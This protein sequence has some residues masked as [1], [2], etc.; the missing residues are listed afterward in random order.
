MPKYKGK[1]LTIGETTYRLG[2]QVGSGGNSY[3]CSA[4]VAGDHTQYAIKFLTISETDDNYANKKERFFREI[5]YCEKTNSKYVIKVYGHGI[6][7]GK[8]CY[9]M[10]R[11]TKTLAKTIA[12]ENDAFALLDCCLQLCDALKYIHSQSIIHRDI[13]PEN[14]F[15]DA[16]NNLVLADFGIAHFFDSSLTSSRD[17]LGNKYYAAP[18]QLL[19]GNSDNVTVA[20]DIYALGAVIN[21]LFTKQKP[22]GTNFITIS[23]KYPYLAK[24]D[25][26]VYRCLRQ[27]PIERPS[28][29]AIFNEIQLLVE[30]LKTKIDD[31]QDFLWP[32]EIVD[33]EDTKIESITKMASF[34][35]LSANYIF[36]EK[37]ADKLELYNPNFHGNVCYN[38]DGILK[39]I[40]FQHCLL[41]KCESKFAYEA[42]VYSKGKPY[43]ALNLKKKSDFQIYTRFEKLLETFSIPNWRFDISGKILKTFSS[44]C[45]YHCKE[46]IR[47]ALFIEQK[48]KD[49]DNSPIIY[50]I[51]VL[52][53]DL[54][55][56]ISQEIALEDHLSINWN[57]I[58]IGENDEQLMIQ[59]SDDKEKSILKEFQAKWGISFGKIDANYYSVSF[60]SK[61]TYIQFKNFALAFSK[62]DYVFEG[63]VLDLLR[64]QREF[65]DIVELYPLG[66]Y[67]INYVLARLFGKIDNC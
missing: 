27:D 39:S 29:N 31:I 64:I 57:T 44:C 22:N 18:E 1:T 33:L 17:W 14:I 52:R 43:H 3:I 66:D 47:E 30:E 23:D 37:S 12:E 36:G 65:L 61:D 45:D 24:L 5:E 67:E 63:D 54:N 10:P 11:Y 38:V 15:V 8:L 59:N 46:L 19:K 21:Q 32:A 51:R 13:K 25:D 6:F 28:I 2:G 34:D 53:S 48:I 41:K 60:S 26:I 62:N 55:K 16:N 35:I 40:Y 50:L 4:S 7:E 49:L 42:N 56:E 9:V 20:C 58:N